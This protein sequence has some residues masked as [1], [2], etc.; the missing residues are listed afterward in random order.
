MHQS[1]WVIEHSQIGEDVSVQ[2]KTVLTEFQIKR[3]LYAYI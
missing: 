2:D 3:I 1:I